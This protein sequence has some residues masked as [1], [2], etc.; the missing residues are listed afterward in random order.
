[1]SDTLGSELI[2]GQI[3]DGGEEVDFGFDAL[4]GSQEA[5][6]NET[7]LYKFFDLA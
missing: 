1:M 2:S 5:Y 3:L 4:S 7:Q 6:E